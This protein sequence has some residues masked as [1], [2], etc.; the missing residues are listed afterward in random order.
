MLFVDDS[1]TTDEWTPVFIVQLLYADP[2]L[3]VDRLKMMTP[4]PEL[5]RL[6]IVFTYE[7]G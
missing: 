6:Q 1:F 7:K 4:K 3:T 2:D 5:G